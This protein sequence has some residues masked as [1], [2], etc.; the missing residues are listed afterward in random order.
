MES[1]KQYGEGSSSNFQSF[2]GTMLPFDDMSEIY[3]HI[4]QVLRHFEGN[5]ASPCIPELGKSSATIST[6]LDLGQHDAA[7]L[8]AMGITEEII[9]LVEPLLMK[10]ADFAKNFLAAQSVCLTP[11]Q[12]ASVEKAVILH[13]MGTTAD[14]YDAA[15]EKRAGFEQG[16]KWELNTAFV[17][18]RF[19]MLPKEIQA[20]IVSVLFQHGSPQAVP[21]FWSYATQGKWSDVVAELRDFYSKPSVLSIRRNEEAD[22]ILLGM[23]RIMQGLCAV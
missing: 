3:A 17:P 9:A 15:L 20:V 5:T 16:E 8:R 6:G 19:S 13:Y 22:M 21:R 11:A 7:S 12:N 23:R 18:T 10:D 1:E 14:A 4:R 2:L